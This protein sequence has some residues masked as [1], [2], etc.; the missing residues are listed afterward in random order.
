MIG[1][2][3]DAVERLRYISCGQQRATAVY[4]EGGR[5]G[6][7][8]YPEFSGHLPRTPSSHPF[9]QGCA[10]CQ[11]LFQEGALAGHVLQDELL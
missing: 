5:V 3:D 4:S 11:C 8:G 7:V 1:I 10:Q 2:V 9:V 6:G